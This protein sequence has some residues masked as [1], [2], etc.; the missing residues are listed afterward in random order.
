MRLYRHLRGSLLRLLRF[1]RLWHLLLLIWF[2]TDDLLNLPHWWQLNMGL[3]FPDLTDALLITGLVDS[4]GLGVLSH[5]D[6]LFV[7]PLCWL[8]R[9]GLVLVL[10]LGLVSAIGLVLLVNDISID[11]LPAFHPVFVLWDVFSTRVQAEWS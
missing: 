4:R 5:C 7:L 1:T 8:L 9:L 10:R 3:A 6:E 2:S 11:A